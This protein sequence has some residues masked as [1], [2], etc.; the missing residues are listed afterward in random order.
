MSCRLRR[1]A[2]DPVDENDPVFIF[3]WPG[4]ALAFTA[5]IVRART[6]GLALVAPAFPDSSGP[7]IIVVLL[8]H[9]FRVNELRR[10]GFTG[11]DLFEA[12]EACAARATQFISRPSTASG[13]PPGNKSRPLLELEDENA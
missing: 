3:A 7:C 4:I 13:E 2:E 8:L 5:D 11:L 12:V 6:L 1:L 9:R 10:G